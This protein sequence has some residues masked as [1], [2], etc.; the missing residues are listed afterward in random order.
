MSLVVIKA[1]D[2]SGALERSV[3]ESIGEP[4]RLVD[5]FA[6]EV[7]FFEANAELFEM[8]GAGRMESN[9]HRK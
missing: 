6:E 7:A 8:R 3:L 5:D 4:S 9:T 2:N 1:I